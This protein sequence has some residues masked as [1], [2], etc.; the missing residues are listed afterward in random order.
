MTRG[1]AEATGSPSHRVKLLQKVVKQ[2]RIAPYG[3]NHRK[4]RAFPRGSKFTQ[5]AEKQPR[6]G[7][8]GKARRSRRCWPIGATYGCFMAF[9]SR[10]TRW[11]GAPIVVAAPVHI[12]MLWVP[13]VLCGVHFDSLLHVGITG[14]HRGLSGE[15]GNVARYAVFC[16]VHRITHSDSNT[17]QHEYLVIRTR[18]HIW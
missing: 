14:N 16:T 1:A 4:W 13:V 2:V 8:R 12:C 11:E 18:Y 10:A 7:P 6:H 15:H 9:A 17:A 5:I 3:Q